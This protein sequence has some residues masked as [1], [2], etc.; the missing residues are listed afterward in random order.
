[1]GRGHERIMNEG[2]FSEL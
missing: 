1:M 2:N